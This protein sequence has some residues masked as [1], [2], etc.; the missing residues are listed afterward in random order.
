MTTLRQMVVIEWYSIA[1]GMPE[2][3]G[4]YL[5]AFTDGTVETYPIEQDQINAGDIRDGNIHGVWW[6]R[7][8]SYPDE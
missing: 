6:A 7:C 2:T 3:E 4:T 5:V 1:D 8:L